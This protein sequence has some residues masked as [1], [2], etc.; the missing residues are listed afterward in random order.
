MEPIMNY[1]INSPPSELDWRNE[2]RVTNIKDQD[3]CGSCW[4][5]GTIGNLEGLYKAKKGKLKSFSEQMLIDCFAQNDPCN[6]GGG[7]SPNDA[8]D[9]IKKNGIMEESAYPYAKK[10]Q[11]CNKKPDLY[12]NLKVKS[13]NI[14]ANFSPVNEEKIAEFLYQNGPLIVGLNANT[15]QNYKSGILDSS[16]SQC[17]PNGINHIVT[18][19]GYGNEKGKDYWIV[20]NSWGENFG[21]NGYFRIRKGKGTC[22]INKF[23]TTAVLDETKKLIFGQYLFIKYLI[24]LCLLT[25]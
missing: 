18:L 10:K 1:A 7:Y 17:D 5:F 16:D 3:P 21:E 20:K 6:G 14:L 2:G 13:Y 9:W 22:G 15:L 25:I 11:T 23:V 12:V 24:L 19:I 4:A 8:I